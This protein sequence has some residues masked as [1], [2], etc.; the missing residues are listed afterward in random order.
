ME[1]YVTAR[2]RHSFFPFVLSEMVLSYAV[3][4][5]AVPE[6]DTPFAEFARVQIDFGTGLNSFMEESSE[7][8]ARFSDSRRH[9]R[10]LC[11]VRDELLATKGLHLSHYAHPFN[12]YTTVNKSETAALRAISQAICGMFQERRDR[13]AVVSLFHSSG[14]YRDDLMELLDGYWEYMD[15]CLGLEDSDSDSSSSSSSSDH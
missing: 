5:D 14:A 3:P 12:L 9:R 8:I 6:T 15:T 13:D 7:I 2:I 4:S 11:A 10:V 1:E